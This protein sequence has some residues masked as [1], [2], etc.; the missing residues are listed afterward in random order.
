MCEVMTKDGKVVLKS[1]NENNIYQVK[2]YLAKEG[3]RPI[4]LKEG[5]ELY[6]H[7]NLSTLKE[8]DR[9][10]LLGWRLKPNDKMD[11]C[12]T[13]LESKITRSRIPKTSNKEYRRVGEL[14]YSDIWGPS[15]IQSYNNCRYVVTFIDAFSKYIVAIPIQNKGEVFGLFKAYVSL[16][17]TQLNVKVKALRSD[18]GGE[19]I[20]NRMKKFCVE[21]GIQ[22]Q[23]T[24]TY[25]SFENGV[26]ERTNRILIEGTRCL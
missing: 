1:V 19:Y 11:F 20:S 15:P 12:E 10:N 5:H 24:H 2:A 23:L 7:L 18:N 14:I 17:E 25:S 9:R 3:D 13:C 4:S 21:K 6:G 22:Q 8:M 26:A 16:V